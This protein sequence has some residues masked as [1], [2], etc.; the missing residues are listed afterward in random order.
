MAL[1]SDEI[2]GE[3]FKKNSWVYRGFSY[4]F[5]NPFWD[6]KIPNGFSL[7]PY[8]WVAISAW[9][10]FIPFTP[11][12]MLFGHIKKYIKK[13]ANQ[14]AKA[15][16]IPLIKG[17]GQYAKEHE[18]ATNVTKKIV[19]ITGLVFLGALGLFCLRAGTAG[20]LT[21][22]HSSQGLTFIFWLVMSCF[23]T[24]I[25]CLIY[26]SNNSSNENRC[27]VEVYMLA[28]IVLAILAT[29]VLQTEHCLAACSSIWLGIKTIVWGIGQAFYWAGWTLYKG[30]YWILFC[31]WFL[32]KLVALAM[33]ST[34]MMGIP[35]ILWLVALV[36]VSN[37]VVVGLNKM[38]EKARTIA[39]NTKTTQEDWQSFLCEVLDKDKRAIEPIES[40]I[41]QYHDDMN[42]PQTKHFQYQ[43][44]FI[45]GR[46]M[47]DIIY[48]ITDFPEKFTDLIR[49]ELSKFKS[50]YRK[51]KH[52]EPDEDQLR[53]FGW[54]LLKFM[55]TEKL[56]DDRTDGWRMLYTFEDEI[57]S[58]FNFDNINKNVHAEMERRKAFESYYKPYEM[59]VK[60]IVI[61][62]TEKE[63]KQKERNRLLD[64]CCKHCTAILSPILKFLKKACINIFWKWTFR[65]T[66]L[67]IW[68]VM[69]N[70]GILFLYL[71]KV[72]KARK[73]GVCP[74]MPFTDVD[75]EPVTEK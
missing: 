19:K 47:R 2:I 52:E 60:E 43:I 51:K 22:I 48:N 46:I 74:Y 69:R 64:E 66:G 29:C 67:A 4:W 7:C 55:K 5:K 37:K 33:L 25:P 73:Q 8:F 23:A 20:Y 9:L 14:F 10:F 6:K 75:Q 50:I 12:F 54:E 13:K 72:G 58:L 40:S 63:E 41:R 31:V 57:Y 44:K 35:I 34:I 38:E 27:K 26:L 36:F 65:T 21:Y 61:V 30:A 11:V 18:C 42:M 71:I 49:A 39:E 56:V 24:F 53:I 15:L 28:W 17:T 70:T 32:I 1:V 59:K 16:I 62:E 45:A 68:C 3:W